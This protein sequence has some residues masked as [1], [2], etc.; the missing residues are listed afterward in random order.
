MKTSLLRAALVV[1]ALTALLLAVPYVAMLLTD[2]VNW[3]LLD[4]VAAGV[5]L[6]TAGMAYS[7]VARR[8][9]STPQ[10]FGLAL[11]VLLVLGL[12]WAELA[13]GLFH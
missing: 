8:A 10:R 6:F 3:T 1:A 4:F 13:V 11:L 7:L 2:E 9:R 5:L 12:V